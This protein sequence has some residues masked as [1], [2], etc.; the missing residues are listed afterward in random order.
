MEE[1]APFFKNSGIALFFKG[2][3]AVCCFFI[4]QE[5]ASMSSQHEAI[6]SHA[7]A[8]CENRCHRQSAKKAWE[9]RKPGSV[10]FRAAIIYLAPK[11]PVVS[12]D[13]PE[14]ARLRA[15]VYVPAGQNLP[16]A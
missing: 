4:R 2:M 13:Q 11:L 1:K 16:A 10:R 9:D 15:A 7:I 14:R 5:I 3:E 12:S 6:S 8:N